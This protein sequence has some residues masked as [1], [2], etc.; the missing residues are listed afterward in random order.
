MNGWERMTKTILK[1]KGEV[2]LGEAGPSRHWT[3]EYECPSRQWKYEYDQ[4]STTNQQM[5]PQ[6]LLPASRNG[7]QVGVVGKMGPKDDD[8][9]ATL[10]L[11]HLDAYTNWRTFQ[12]LP[13][14]ICDAEHHPHPEERLITPSTWLLS[15]W[16][17]NPP[18]KSCVCNGIKYCSKVSFQ[19]GQL[20]RVRSMDVS[21][22]TPCVSSA[23]FCHSLCSLRRDSLSP[24]HVFLNPVVWIS[25]TIS[26][27]GSTLNLQT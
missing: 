3:Y 18:P 6:C 16:K 27:W 7:F 11:S 12:N 2:R 15:W 14:T 17:G 21:A 5:L 26:S 8:E 13:L 19:V 24:R 10:D 9:M 23:R 22:N 25:R 20:G 4:N 1:K